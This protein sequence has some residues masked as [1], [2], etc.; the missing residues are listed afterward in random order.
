MPRAGLVRTA[1]CGRLGVN[2]GAPFGYDNRSVSPAA[3]AA[4]SGSELS[5]DGHIIG[6]ASYHA[7]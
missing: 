1:V 5:K 2:N 4:L 7:A 6:S 3:W